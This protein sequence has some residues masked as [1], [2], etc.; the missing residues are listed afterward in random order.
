ME[1]SGVLASLVLKKS[2]GRY[3]TLKQKL[4]GKMK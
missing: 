2:M 1:G 3:G 4:T